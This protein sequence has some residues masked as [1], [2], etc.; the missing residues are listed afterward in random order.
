MVV[1]ANGEHVT[2]PPGARLPDLLAVLGLG[3][4]RGLLDLSVRI[5]SP[6]DATLLELQ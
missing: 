1:L 6:M 3:A 5:P 4:R 2:L